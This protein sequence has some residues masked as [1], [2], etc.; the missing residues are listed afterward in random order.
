M[1]EWRN[2]K[3]AWAFFVMGLALAALGE[4][5][6]P[7]GFAAE[8]KQGRNN[9]WRESGTLDEVYSSGLR[10]VGACLEGQGYA[11][12]Y[13]IPMAGGGRVVQQWEKDGERI[14]VMVWEKRDG[15]TGLSWGVSE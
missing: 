9:T 5:R 3:T 10:T 13:D 15:R 6:M 14:I 2:R 7:G 8:W 12:Q 4:P 11:L 1:A